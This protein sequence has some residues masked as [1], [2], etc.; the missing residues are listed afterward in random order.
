M[1]KFSSMSTVFNR[2]QVLARKIQWC[3]W[4]RCYFEPLLVL[5]EAFH[6]KHLLEVCVKIKPE[7]KPWSIKMLL[8]GQTHPSGELFFISCLPCLFRVAPGLFERGLIYT[9]LVGPV[10]FHRSDQV[11]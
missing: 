1:I 8:G 10:L 4:C 6:S 11:S 2:V 9:T 3:I 5:L 7:S